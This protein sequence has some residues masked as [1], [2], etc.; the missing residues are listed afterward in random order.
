MTTAQ[1]GEKLYSLAKKRILLGFGC[2]CVLL[3]LTTAALTSYLVYQEATRPTGTTSPTT[4]P[5]VTGRGK[6][7]LHCKVLIIGSGFAGSFAAFQ[8]APLYGKDLCLVEKSDRDGGR[9]YDISE[10]PNGPVFGFGALRVITGQTGMQSLARVLNITFQPD[11]ADVELLKVRGQF[12]FRTP[13]SE[14][15]KLCNEHFSGMECY[16]NETGVPTDGIM[17]G[18]LLNSRY[19]LPLEQ[20]LHMPEAIDITSQ[21]LALFGDEGFDFFR[22]CLRYN[23]LMTSI[24]VQGFLDFL[25]HEGGGFDPQRFYPVGGMSSYYKTMMAE[26]SRNGMR[27]YREEPVEEIAT[28]TL[29]EPLDGAFRVETRS[30]DIQTDKVLC[31]IDPSNF[32]GVAGNVAESV[33][34][35]EEFGWIVPKVAATV[36]AWWDERWW[37]SS[38]HHGTYNL[39]RAVSHENCFNMMDIPTFPYAMDENV[40]RA[41]YDDGSCVDTWR[42]LIND[43]TRLEELTDTVVKSLQHFFDDVVV[44]RPRFLR[45]HVFENAWHFQAPQSS[46][47]NQEV[48]EW[49]QRPT[50]YENFVLIGEAYNLNYAA[51]CDGALRSSMTALMN[52]YNFTYPCCDDTDVTSTTI[53]Q[54][55]ETAGKRRHSP[56]IHNLMP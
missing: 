47:T 41:V 34:S 14:T 35:A 25:A 32:H 39:T 22:E 29:Q 36:S 16:N 56:N 18:E 10:R 4:G 43:E 5:S 33:K 24:S 26:A 37:E 40:T 6:V 44:P 13:V 38:R 30:F 19:E 53:C 52:F 8:L 31:S 28:L 45:G 3:L 7:K 12:Y 20:Q 48:F 49:S 50:Q 23:S 51:W 17:M 9:I 2:L 55:C 11:L 54:P 21:G 42:L 27:V 15:R 1:V 46:K